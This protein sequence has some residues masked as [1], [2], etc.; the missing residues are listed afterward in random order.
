MNLI[1]SIDNPNVKKWSKLKSKKYRDKENLFI[2]EGE[3]LVLEALKKAQVEEVILDEEKIFPIDVKKTYVTKEILK[4]LTFLETPPDIL[5]IVKKLPEKPYGH[6]LLL[7]D[8]LQDPGNLGT[9]IRTSVAFDSDTIVLGENSVDLYN[10]K[11]IR[12]TQG[13]LFSTNIIKRN[14]KDFVKELKKQN[15][16]ILGTSVTHGVS[17]YDL[18]IK[19]KYAFIMGNEGSGV[20]EE[21]L[22]LCDNNLYIP[23]KNDCESLNVAVACGIILYEL[24]KKGDRK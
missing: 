23:M 16:Q 19:D 13:L 8:S 14:L 21:L 6:K 2:V 12:A 11:T 20:S 3:H 9:I 24:D 7:I 5:A 17:L 22:N 1:T 10:E 15:F 18:E 4:K